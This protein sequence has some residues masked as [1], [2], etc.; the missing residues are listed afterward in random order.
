MSSGRSVTGRDGYEELLN[1]REVKMAGY[2]PN[3]FFACSL[4]IIT[5]RRTNTITTLVIYRM[6]SLATVRFSEQIIPTDKSPSIISRQI[7]VII[8]HGRNIMCSKILLKIS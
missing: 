4:A 1:K 7:E 5:L 3:Y 2:W 6:F 8:L